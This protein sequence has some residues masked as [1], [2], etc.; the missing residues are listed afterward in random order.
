MK[1]IFVYVLEFM[2]TLD[3][4]QN[5]S[6]LMCKKF[7]I[8]GQSILNVIHSVRIV[9]YIVCSGPVIGSS[10]AKLLIIFRPSTAGIMQLTSQ[11]LR[12]AIGWCASPQI[13]N[14]N[15]QISLCIL[16]YVM[17]IILMINIAR[18]LISMLTH[19][20]HITRLV[21]S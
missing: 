15:M 20:G 13:I 12:T 2:L 7:K 3:E 9:L 18:I 8:G 17:P 16:H 6:I 14:R 10:T 19:F 1:G 21:L 5:I 4:M 11:I